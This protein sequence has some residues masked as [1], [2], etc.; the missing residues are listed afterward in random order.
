M[1]DALDFVE[2]PFVFRDVDGEILFSGTPDRMQCSFNLKD[3]IVTDYKMGRLPV[4]P[5]ESNLQ[6]RAYLCM[7]PAPDDFVPE[8]YQPFRPSNLLRRKSCPGSLALESTLPES[9]S[10]Y[11]GGKYA[12]EGTTLHSHLA[13]RSKPR[14]GLEP[15][16]FETLEKAE[17]MESE[18]LEI[19]KQQMKPGWGYGAII[20][21]RIANKPFIVAYS[22]KDLEASR[23][24]IITL[25]LAAHEPHAKRFA[26]ADACRYC[27]ATAICE[28]HK[29][30]IMA[31]EKIAHLPA[32]SWTPDQ[33][34]LFL[35]R[36]S[37]LSRFIDER[38]EEAKAIKAAEPDRI[39]GW[40]LQDGNERR[41][42]ASVVE[43]WQRLEGKLSAGEFSECCDL[44]LGALEKAIWQS[45][46]DGPDKLSQKAVKQLVNQALDE[47]ITKKRNKPS[48]VKTDV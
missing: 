14:D 19:V 3:R 7:E 30:W 27:R 2:Q 47:I 33:W 11:D 36:E 4:Q 26:S 16:Q 8:T 5:A 46:R 20:Q 44:S 6:L 41:V 39:P 48:L 40:E 22:P 15:E 18:F 34:D 43:A 9:P 10:D 45:R 37:A 29:T 1:I 25:W 35:T 38:R 31:V 32:Y 24:E 12:E 42:V 13:D 17:A 21:P 23:R 28:E